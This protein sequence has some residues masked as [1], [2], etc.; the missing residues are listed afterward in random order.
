MNLDKF[1][2]KVMEMSKAKTD[3][4]ENKDSM[5]LIDK[6]S[7]D[8]IKNTIKESKITELQELL[9]EKILNSF[10]MTDIFPKFDKPDRPTPHQMSNIQEKEFCNLTVKEILTQYSNLN[11]FNYDLYRNTDL[12]R[13]KKRLE[14][15]K[16]LRN[17]NRTLVMPETPKIKNKEIPKI[18]SV[19]LSKGI[20][21]LI[22]NKTIPF[23]ADV[24]P[25]LLDSELNTLTIEPAKFYTTNQPGRN[26]FPKIKTS[27]YTGNNVQLDVSSA[28]QVEPKPLEIYV[29][30]ETKLKNERMVVKT[31][32]I[33]TNFMENKEKI[34]NRTYNE[35]LDKFSRHIIY[36]RNGVLL[37]DTPEFQSFHRIYKKNWKKIELLLV[38][39]EEIFKEF[40]VKL[41]CLDGNQL[42]ALLN[43][44]TNLTLFQLLSA[45]DN[46]NEVFPL[47]KVA[48]I[49]FKLKNG[50]EIAVI[51]IQSWYRM[52]Y[53]RKCY[54][55]YRLRDLYARIIQVYYKSYK[56][57]L[58]QMTEFKDYKASKRR[59]WERVQSKFAKATDDDLYKIEIFI[60]CLSYIEY[61]RQTFDDLKDYECLY[62]NRIFALK[63]PLL[64]L[65]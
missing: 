29:P 7:K 43:L 3:E 63:D 51:L 8:S 38:H 34:N 19:D 58:K 42:V 53:T 24:S 10:N 57:M 41:V 22:T 11:R 1:F 49:R 21:E 18:L 59:K 33:T 20:N 6:I 17:Y 26:E 64:I 48:G 44:K 36:I 52:Y 12:I 14:D 5:V 56:A 45:V 35:L 9:R 2:D 60:P 61:R 65:M 31:T 50:P 16:Y 47:M 37:K 15:I 28:I 55:T 54:K 4:I 46:Q 32:N 23:D 39:L 13:N 30:N 27:N 25:F 62:I 40:K